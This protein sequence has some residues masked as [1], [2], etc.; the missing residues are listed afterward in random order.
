L[1]DWFEAVADPLAPAALQHRQVNRW[2]KRDIQAPAWPWEMAN[3]LTLAARTQ[4]GKWHHRGAGMDRQPTYPGLDLPHL[5]IATG[6]FGKN[7]DQPASPQQGQTDF[8][9]LAARTAIDRHLTAGQHDL[10]QQPFGQFL[11]DQ[12]VNAARR[13]PHHHRSVH[14]PGVVTGQYGRAGRN[15]LGT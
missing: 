3:R 4:T 14:Q 11:F 1:G 6:A 7:A 2:A 5:A 12:E 13:R 10:A 9:G 8:Q 15:L